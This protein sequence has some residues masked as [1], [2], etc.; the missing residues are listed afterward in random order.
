MRH[1]CAILDDYQT[2]ALKLAD[3]SAV[4]GDLDI[5]VFNSHL[6][7]PARV[8]EALKDKSIVCLMRERTPLPRAVIEA[9]PE[10]KLIVTTG[11]YNASVDLAAAKERG[12]LVCG[13][14]GIGAPTA[15]LAMGLILD[16]ARSISFENARLKAGDPWQVTMGIDLAGQ[17]LGLLGLGKLGQRVAKLAQAFD[18]KVIA[19]SQNLT[20]E[21]CREAGVGYVSKEQ[22]FS[23]S[24]F[25]SVHLVLSDRTRGLVGAADFARMKP[26]A[27]FVNTSRG[28]IVQERALIEAL[29][30]KKIAGAGIDVYDIEP[31]P[32]DHKLRK[33]PN[34]VLTPHLG[35]VTEGNYR[36]FFRDTVEDIRAFLDGK[37]V[38]VVTANK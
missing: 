11:M 6:G 13:T 24:D 31:L 4:S 30:K 7:E 12:I 25:I 33:L 16:L 20:E 10:L 38:R 22:L 34:A 32:T 36:V 27:F 14:R 8:I 2:V 5:Q 29:E 18:M 3:W 1:R 23:Q 17:T 15:D 21:R 37:P 26:T 19:W 9:L 35:Y 28:P